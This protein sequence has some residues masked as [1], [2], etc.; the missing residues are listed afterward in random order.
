MAVL[1]ES[2]VR[3]AL[4]KVIDPEIR[5][6]ITDLGMVKSIDISDDGAVGV[7]IYLTT[8]GC[9]MKTE[10][11]D[12]VKN[13]VADV[14]G[15]GTV[16]VEL[17][18]M[19]DEQRTELRKSLRGDSAEPIIPFA[20]PGSLTRVYAVASGKGGVGKSSVTVNLAASLTARG[21][22]VGVLDADIYGHSVPRMLG[23]DARPTQVE[24]M[25]MPP[26]AHGVKFISIAQFTQ[27]NTPVVWRGPMLHRAL[28]QFLADVF[29]GD[30]D[31]LLLDLPPGTGD[32][33]ISV[34]QLIPSA[35]ILVVTTPQQ[36][37]AE[38]AERAGAI[39]LQ[40]RQRVAG[41]VEN[42]SWLEL[43]DGTRMDIFGSGGG[44]D[45]SDRLTKAVGASVPLLGQI[46]LDTAV[47]EG[48]DA[49]TP[50]VLSNPESPAAQALEAVAAKLAVRERGL[51]GMS[52]GIDS[53]RKL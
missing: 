10:I 37:A 28:Q 13:A 30:L 15:V 16:T 34:A 24:K 2:D 22:S 1:T 19:N 49:G 12:R 51:V 27:G 35:E 50:I 25:I 26:Q 14:A 7:G 48:G 4:T 40:T 29:W 17:D 20:Q 39:A 47:R 8:S 5:K 6:P 41:V 33:A 23:N 31:V 3:T 18:V 32:V 9:P 42:M 21:L 44:Q 52:L 43:P 38:V 53:A 45:V 46:P 36:A 11:S